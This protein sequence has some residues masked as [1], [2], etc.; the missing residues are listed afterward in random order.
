MIE[1]NASLINQTSGRDELRPGS[2]DALAAGC[3]CPVLDNGRG[4]G[5]Y[6]GG[7]LD[8]EGKPLYWINAECPIHGSAKE[9]TTE[10]PVGASL[11]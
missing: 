10:N 6:G 8:E 9:P 7:L 2:N 5:A 1:N 11:C 3:L 4:K